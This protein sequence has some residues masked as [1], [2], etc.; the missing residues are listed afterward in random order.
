MDAAT[1]YELIGYVGSALVVVSLMMRSLLR[2]RAINLLGAAIFATYGVLIDAPPVWAVN[3]AIVVI[4]LYH[5][6]GMLRGG[7]EYFEVL[8]VALDS[9][10]LDRFLSF[11]AEDI[12]G[13]QPSWNGLVEGQRAFFVLRD[14]VPAGLVVL[15][16]G[17]DPDTLEV[18]LDF[19]IEG[20]RDFKLGSWVYRETDL[21]GRAR[22]RL[23]TAPGSP[24][25]QRYLER[26]GFERRGD[27]YVR[28]LT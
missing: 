28:A 26:M 13:F 4:D 2:L 8:E 18:D 6:R 16:E 21:L 27:R 1:V 24:T 14:L 19:V 5:L 22:R 25:H 3:G 10:Y 11:H 23:V 20:Y 12:A 17:T 7:D 15:R 9:R